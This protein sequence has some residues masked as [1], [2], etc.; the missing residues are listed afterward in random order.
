MEGCFITVSNDFH[1]TSIILQARECNGGYL[2]TKA[3]ARMAKKRLCGKRGCICTDVAGTLPSR[4]EE[5]LNGDV[6][7][8]PNHSPGASAS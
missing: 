2:I 7:L 4:G 5:Q 1:G 6:I 3:Q 8:E